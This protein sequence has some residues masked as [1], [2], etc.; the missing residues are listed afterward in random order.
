VAGESYA[1]DR[2]SSGSRSCYI[3]RA[4][5]RRFV[6]SYHMELNLS[7]RSCTP[8]PSLEIA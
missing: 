2:Y 7:Q 3:V 8:G 4:L 5:S 6:S 1:Q